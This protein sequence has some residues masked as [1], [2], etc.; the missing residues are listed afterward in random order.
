LDH[1]TYM[2]TQSH[3]DKRIDPDSPEEVDA[4]LHNLRSSHPRHPGRNRWFDKPFNFVVETNTRAGAIGEHS[5]VDALVPSILAEYAVVQEIDEGSFDPLQ[6]EA[7]TIEAATT[8]GWRR[9]DWVVDE[10]LRQE[11]IAAEERARTIVEDSDD[12]VLWFNGY[13][14]QWIKTEGQSTYHQMRAL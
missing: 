13:G 9:L 3:T 1:Y 12:S 4:H 6:S 8:V 2:P 14:T 5:P 7:E 10:H 11:C